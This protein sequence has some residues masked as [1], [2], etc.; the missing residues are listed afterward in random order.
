[1]L[2]KTSITNVRLKSNIL[3]KI[4]VN[5]IILS[6]SFTE[7]DQNKYDSKMICTE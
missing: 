5:I 1:M 6:L 3:I 7:N 2:N 4:E